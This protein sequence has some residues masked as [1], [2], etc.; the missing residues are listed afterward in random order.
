GINELKKKGKELVDK[1]H[2]D[3]A[4][5]DFQMRN[6]SESYD[7]LINQGLK[8]KTQPENAKEK[9]EIYEK[10]LAD[11]EAILEDHMSQMSQTFLSSTDRDSDNEL[12]WFVAENELNSIEWIKQQLDASSWIK[13]KLVCPY[14]RG[15]RLGSYDFVHDSKCACNEHVLPSVHLVKSHVD[16]ET[17][18]QQ[19]P[20]CRKR[21]SVKVPCFT[22]SFCK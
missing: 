2:C 9:Y 14:N 18:S 1:Y 3:K 12:L 13:G 17:G 22:H 20:V 16:F 6:V 21:C 11:C 19:S 10:T 7:A 15:T 5:I 4:K 8:I